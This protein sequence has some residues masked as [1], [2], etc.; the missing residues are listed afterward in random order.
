MFS[1]SRVLGLIGFRVWGFGFN[2]R[3]LLFRAS[4]LRLPGWTLGVQ[5]IFGGGPRVPLPTQSEALWAR[6]LHTMR[7]RDRGAGCWAAMV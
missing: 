7:A 6:Q 5:G 3:V 4:G 2:Y 1:L